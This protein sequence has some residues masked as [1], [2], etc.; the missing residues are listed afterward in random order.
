MEPGFGRN[1]MQTREQRW[2]EE[3]AR[4]ACHE[5]SLQGELLPT[6]EQKGKM[7]GWGK[8]AIVGKFEYLLNRKIITLGTPPILISRR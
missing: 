2:P 6:T 1:A 8:L 5:H 3:Q 4:R 7:K